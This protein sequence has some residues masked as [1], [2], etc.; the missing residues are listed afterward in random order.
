MAADSNQTITRLQGRYYS[1][2]FPFIPICAAV[3]LDRYCS[4]LR[5]PQ[6]G[7]W[8]FVIAGILAL[9]ALFVGARLGRFEGSFGVVDFPD[10]FFMRQRG[11]RFCVLAVAVLITVLLLKRGRHGATWFIV[12]WAILMS[13]PTIAAQHWA[14]TAVRETNEDR[15]PIA[16]KHLIGPDEKNAGLIVASTYDDG[17]VFRVMFYLNSLSHAI[18]VPKGSALGEGESIPIASGC[19][20]WTIIASSCRRRPSSKATASS[21]K[22]PEVAVITARHGAW[23]RVMPHRAVGFEA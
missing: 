8:V 4:D 20:C 3:V 2:A 12:Y 15:F 16:V 10:T 17:K 1:F 22:T 7:V 14:V 6:R 23:S 21:C 18:I 19:F 9:L 11:A 13:F 5:L